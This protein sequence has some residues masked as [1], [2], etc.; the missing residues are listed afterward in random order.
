MRSRKT[1]IGA[2]NHDFVFSI[3]CGAMV[4]VECAHHVSLANYTA[5]KERPASRRYRHAECNSG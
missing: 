3:A 5:V 2:C 4:Y 1:S